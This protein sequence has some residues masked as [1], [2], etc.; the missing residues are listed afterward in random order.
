MKLK[1]KIAIN[2]IFLGKKT[3]KKSKVFI[4]LQWGRYLQFDHQFVGI[5]ST[6]LFD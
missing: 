2:L 1:N 6:F 5:Y 3:D 4:H